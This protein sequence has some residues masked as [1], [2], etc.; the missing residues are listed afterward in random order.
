MKD[1]KDLKN[2][3]IDED[4]EE[5]EIFREPKILKHFK[6]SRVETEMFEPAENAMMPK[7]KHRK[8]K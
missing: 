4:L 6:K 2:L 8:R 7:P 5:I 1:K 3:I